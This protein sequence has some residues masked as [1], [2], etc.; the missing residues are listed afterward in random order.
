MILARVLKVTHNGEKINTIYVITKLTADIESR[1]VLAQA[2]QNK[3]KLTEPFEKK[4]YSFINVILSLR[5][6]K[7]FSFSFLYEVYVTLRYLCV[8]SDLKSG[9][10]I[11]F[12]AA[13]PRTERAL[14]LLGVC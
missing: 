9:S 1:D 2:L 5:Q 6:V 13:Q 14:P 8:A 12:Q 11:I 7:A 10:L 4:Y 3:I